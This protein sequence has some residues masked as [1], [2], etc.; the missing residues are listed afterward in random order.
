MYVHEILLQSFVQYVHALNIDS[1]KQF[2]N[3]WHTQVLFW[4]YNPDISPCDIFIITAVQGE[5]KHECQ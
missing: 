4:S 5:A 2:Y 1:V 3:T